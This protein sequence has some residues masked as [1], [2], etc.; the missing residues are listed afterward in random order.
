MVPRPADRARADGG[1]VSAAGPTSPS[2]D[3]SRPRAEWL[4]QRERGTIAAIRFT[5]RLAGWI[6]RGPMRVVVRVIALYYCLFDRE[7]VRH[8]RGWLERVHERPAR[9][10]DVFRHV[11]TFAQVTLDRLYFAR[12]DL[13][14]F[15]VTRTGNQHLIEL[16]RRKTGAILLGAHLGSFEAMR[17]VGDGERFPIA[18]VGHFENARMIS[19]LLG[20]LDPGFEGRVIHAGQNS[21]DLALQLKD[22]IDRGDCIA[23]LGDRVGLN[24]KDVVVPFFGQPARF[25]TG[26]F[27]LASVL[28]VPVYLVF[29]LHHPP[30]RYDVYCEPFAERIELPRGRREEALEA[31]VSRY[32]SRLEAMAREAPDNWFN[33][34]DFWED[35][36]Q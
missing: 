33:F 25:A 8:S 30:N 27:L 18:I 24:E 14:P 28:K 10:R 7:V 9:F 17:A 34:F 16:A 5:A 6:G 3:D 31:F 11:S 13:V 4:T 19:A 36:A 20:D 1:R 23:L 21:V 12:G 2:V 22:A 35:R 29:G 15:E 26:P 32:A